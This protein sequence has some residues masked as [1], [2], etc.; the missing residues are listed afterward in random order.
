MPNSSSNA[1]LSRPSAAPP[2]RLIVCADDYALS[3]PTSAAILELARPGRIT[4]TSAMVLSPLWPRAAAEAR[5]VAPY[6]DMGLHLDWTSEFAIAG[7]HGRSL[8]ILMLATSL[9]RLRPHDAE[10][11]IERQLDAFERHM[12]AMP[13]HVDGHQHVHQFP[14][15]RDAL[16][17]VLERRYAG[18]RKPWLRIARPP[19]QLAQLKPRVIALMGADTLQHLCDAAGFAHSNHLIG[20]Y[21]FTG[22]ERRYLALLDGWLRAAAEGDVLMCHP[23]HG[24][25]AGAE[26]AAARGWE[27]KT[28]DSESFP[29]LLQ[30]AGI[31]LQRG[32][33]LFTGTITP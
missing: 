21:D 12:Q 8:P 20:I 5:D 23:G 22:G 14:Q 11:V 2:K 9:R 17:K 6:I 24:E 27:Q 28:L 16:I 25:D 18:K 29:Q 13:D 32:S 31:V 33:R 15:I 4:A 26:L 7:G 3:A 1:A 19:A 30:R 10:A